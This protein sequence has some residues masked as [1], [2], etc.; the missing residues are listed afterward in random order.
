MINPHW[1]DEKVYQ[2]ARKIIIALL[3]HIVYDE[4]LPRIVGE[5]L[6]GLYNLGLNPDYFH[7]Y[8]PQCQPDILNEFAT[9]AFR[10]GHTL[11]TDDFKLS[12]SL[13]S[14]VVSAANKRIKLRKHINNPDV[15]LSPNFT[16]E[17]VY[18][19][20]EEPSG[21]ADR[22]LVNEIRNH[23]MESKGFDRSGV[24]LGALNIQRGR[25][26]GIRGFV[27]YESYCSKD[28]LQRLA[29]STS[30]KDGGYVG[31]TNFDDLKKRGFDEE[32]VKK[33][34]EV[35]KY[36]EDVDLFTGGLTEPTLPDALVGN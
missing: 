36:V 33:L 31:I 7:D 25:D 3:Q 27:A 26:H 4:F 22:F 29:E 20:V 14:S 11:I 30:P 12:G 15:L 23:L 1:K 13:A 35:Y 16:D 5:N 21:K 17:L 8:D 19:L 28:I 34:E 2:E 10:F 32:S 6:I 24:D 18:G 9:A